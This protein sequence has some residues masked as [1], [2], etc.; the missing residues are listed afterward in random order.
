[1][2]NSILT[3]NMI[4]REAVMLFKNSNLFI[5]NIDTQYDKM[6]AIDGA[7]IGTSV[8][9]RLP[10][11]YVVR[12]GPAM[13]IQDTAEQYT[14]LNLSTQFGVDVGF[15]SVDRTMSLD[16][17]SERILE[18]MMNN[19]VGA[20]AVNIMTNV[21]EGGV[22]NFVSNVNGAGTIISPTQTQFLRAN[23]TLTKNS[24]SMLNRKI[25]L[26][27]DT[28]ANAVSALTGLLNPSSEISSQYMSGMMKSGLGYRKWFEDQTVIT[29]TSGT[30]NSTSTVNGAQN[31]TT[32]LT[33]TALTGTLKAGDIITISGVNAVNWV[34]KADLGTL[35]QF[36][37]TA[38]AANGATSISIFPAIIAPTVAAGPTAANGVAT[39][40]YQSV[41]PIGGA[42]N[43]ATVTVVAPAA[44]TYRKNIAFTR[45]AFTMATA[46]LILPQKGIVEGARA[47]YDGVSLRMITAYLPGT[48]VLATRSDVL[49]GSLSVRPQWACVVADAVA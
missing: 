17:Y 16:D 47:V 6:F 43:G 4:T 48:D 12:S 45:E 37:V 14:T 8:R 24:A 26:D 30:Y 20:C 28:N 41:A 9:I 40:Q 22:C 33:V 23:A 10:N 46:D 13:S 34:T 39:I 19:L 21:V 49:F 35:R 3:I 44:S 2:A 32:T 27:P 11:D 15:T 29:H 31:N 18:P 42:P 25:V 38:N 7:K 36:V 1:M 5:Q